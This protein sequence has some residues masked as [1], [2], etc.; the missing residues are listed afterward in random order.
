[1]RQG[2]LQAI[3]KGFLQALCPMARRQFS[4]AIGVS[5]AVMNIYMK[6]PHVGVDA[7]AGDHFNAGALVGALNNVTRT[8][9]GLL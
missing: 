1:M 8:S 2:K 5:L 6:Q 3:V 9:F 4:Q 7:V